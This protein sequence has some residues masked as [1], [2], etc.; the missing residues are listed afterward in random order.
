MKP[1]NGWSSSF[2]HGWI[3]ARSVKKTTGSISSARR[4]RLRAAVIVPQMS[5]LWLLYQM[6]P[7]RKVLK[8]LA[9]RF[10][11]PLST[12]EQF[13]PWFIQRHLQIFIASST[14]PKKRI[15]DKDATLEQFR[16]TLHDLADIGLLAFCK[17]SDGEKCYSL[18]QL[19]DAFIALMDE[20]S[21]RLCFNSRTLHPTQDLSHLLQY[22]LPINEA[23]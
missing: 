9:K 7:H 16:R 12:L 10:Q 23:S 2:G 3:T 8:D 20:Y 6:Q 14:D 11:L 5:V 13:Y 21:N 17:V 18:Y 15:P 19:N 4:K 1:T 22:W